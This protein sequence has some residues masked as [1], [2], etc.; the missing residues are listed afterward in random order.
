MRRGFG[1]QPERRQL[2]AVH[3]VVHPVAA[4]Q[5]L[6]LD[7]EAGQQRQRRDPIG[8]APGELDGD[9]AA[10]AE[11]DDVRPGLV[12]RGEKRVHVGS[13]RRDAV[14]GDVP[15]RV[16]EPRQIRRD[17]AP[18]AGESVGDAV[19]VEAP[20]GAAVQQDD[21][22][23]AWRALWRTP[24]VERERDV[25]H[26]RVAG[27]Q[28]V[29]AARGQADPRDRRIEGRFGSRARNTDDAARSVR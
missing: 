4:E 10:H 7:A 18:I 21:G 14:V 20:A 12:Q 22:L 3:G 15:G 28:C 8:M 17:H 13:V 26:L 16:S 19:E 23:A 24:A 5:L 27:Q 25:H 2:H 1:Q 6:L 9:A 29:G 11:P